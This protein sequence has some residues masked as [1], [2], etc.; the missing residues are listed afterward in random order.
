MTLQESNAKR[1]AQMHISAAKGPTFEAVAKRLSAPE[2][3][4]RYQA[5]EKTTGVPWQFTAVT[6]EREA[7]QRW[8]TQL[9]Q[10]DPLNRKS[11]H[12][13]KGRGPFTTWEDGAV[14]ALVN[15]APYAARNKDWS[16]GGTLAMLEK[17]NGL[18]YASKGVPSPYIW[19]GTDQYVKGKYVADGVYDPNHVDTQLGCAGLLKFMGWPNKDKVSAPAT[20]VIATGGLLYAMWGHVVA[21]PY[22]SGIIVA[23]GAGLVYWTVHTL[24]NKK[25]TSKPS[26]PDMLT[27]PSTDGGS[28]KSGDQAGPT[29]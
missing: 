16:I 7:S 3:K 9:G 10:G 24:R 25:W 4:K 15:C 20:T 6:H 2:A 8:N 18:G 1:W 19:A 26:S 21:H 14:D 22:L 29:S 28:I 12:V 17:Y 23:V 5:V 11:T 13:P 27:P